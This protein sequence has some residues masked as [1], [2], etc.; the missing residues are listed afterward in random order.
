MPRKKTSSVNDIN[1]NTSNIS[2]TN[3]ESNPNN[4]NNNIKKTKD[5]KSTKTPFLSYTG[6]LYKQK[7]G[8]GILVDINK[9]QEISIQARDLANVWHTDTLS[10][11]V[12]SFSVVH[13]LEIIQRGI[14]NILGKASKQNNYWVLTPEDHKIP[15]MY[16]DNNCLKNIELKKDDIVYA[17]IMSYPDANQRTGIVEIIEVMGEFDDAGIEID[18]AVKKY[19]LPHEFSQEVEKELSQIPN[20][21]AKKDYKCRVDLTDIEFVTIDGED[22]RDFDDAVYCEPCAIYNSKKPNAM[23][24]L[25]AIADVSHY[26]KPQTALDTEAINRATSVYF[27]RKVIPMLPE[28]LSNGLCSL[29]P[30]VDRLCMVCDMVIDAKGNVYAYQ[31]YNAVMHSKARLTYNIVANILDIEKA[32]NDNSS[33]SKSKKD[34]SDLNHEEYNKYIDVVPQINNLYNVFQTLLGAR[35]QRGAIDFDTQETQMLCAENGKIEKIIPR[36]R[37][38]AHRLI[39]ECML[40]ANVCAAD[41]ISKNHDSL[42]RIHGQPNPEKLLQLQNYLQGLGIRLSLDKNQTTPTKNIADVLH[43]IQTRPDGKVLQTMILRT[44]QQAVYDNANIGHYGLAYKAYTHFT[45][46]I[47]RYPD[48]LVHRTI[49][50]ILEQK[51]YEPYIPATIEIHSLPAKNAQGNFKLNNDKNGVNNKQNIEK[52]NPHKPA[53]PNKAKQIWHMLGGHC[54]ALERRA[55]EASRDVEAWLKCYFMQSKVGYT[56]TGCVSAVVPFGLFIQ[57]DELYIDGL[58]HVSELGRDYFVYDEAKQQMYGKQSKKVF[59][60]GDKVT[61]KVTKVDIA[62]RKIDFI[63]VKDD[64]NMNKNISSNLDGSNI[65]DNKNRQINN[66]IKKSDDIIKSSEAKPSRARGAKANARKASSAKSSQTQAKTTSKG[67]S[68]S[69]SKPKSVANNSTKTAK[70]T[71]SKTRKK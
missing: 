1:S 51:T 61:I 15:L 52:I 53:K 57:L 40:A 48:L 35:L 54:S 20:I 55:D 47:R 22:A 64:M 27:P 10:V 32:K 62:S 21:P 17:K 4:I 18:M 59:K 14:T 23:R 37:N 13:S 3:N 30:H 6:R 46:P 67:K 38:D 9:Q 50:S 5:I 58:V 70:S 45:S 28:K 31:F 41:F 42:Y 24:L 63:L 39:E 44:M 2:S 69:Q 16:V 49:K 36:K 65:S 66:R 56:Y 60:I 68:N 71:S 19:N 8:S 43:H 34:K 11:Q 25:V 7:D 33:N 26:V 12:D 29:N